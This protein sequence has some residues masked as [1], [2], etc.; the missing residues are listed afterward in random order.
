MKFYLS[1]SDF[2]VNADLETS[3][4]LPDG[5][6]V[7]IFHKQQINRGHRIVLENLKAIMRTQYLGNPSELNRKIAS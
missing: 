4:F 6:G 1:S 5:S 3:D 7:D 2:E